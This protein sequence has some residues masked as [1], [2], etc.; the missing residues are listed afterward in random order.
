[1]RI[2]KMDDLERG[3]R[4][5]CEDF[6]YGSH[7]DVLGLDPDAEM[8]DGWERI[9]AGERSPAIDAYLEV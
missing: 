2:L 1:M 3:R 6:A 4:N 8:F 5:G 7:G 9:E